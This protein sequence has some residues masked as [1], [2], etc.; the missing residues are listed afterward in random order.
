VRAEVAGLKGV[1]R[2][3]YQADQDVFTVQF[4]REEVTLEA[5]FTAVYAAGKKM[6]R[7]YLPQ[8]LN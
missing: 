2:V 3:A 7:D 5:I 4:D 6:G 8:L 1:S